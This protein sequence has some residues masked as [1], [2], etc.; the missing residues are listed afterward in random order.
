MP[1]Q[2][3]PY[4]A[5]L[6]RNGYD[7]TLL[8]YEKKRDLKEKGRDGIAAMRRDLAA[9]GIEWLYLAY[10]KNPP[11]LSTIFD[12]SV[13]CLRV[14]YIILSRR[15]KIVHLRG[16]TP[17]MMMLPLSRVTD[18]RTVFD[19]RGFLA[20]E[21]V[22]GGI[23]KEG[24]VSFRIVKKAE[25]RLLKTADAVTVLTRKHLDINRASEWLSGRRIPMDVVPCC[26]DT[27][28]FTIDDTSAAELRSRHG[29]NDNFVLMYPGKIGTFYFMK[30]MLDFYKALMAAEPGAV[31][32]IVTRDD[33]GPV[34]KAAEE[35][36]IGGDRVRIIKGPD[37][38][39]MPEY[40]RMADAGIFFIN[41]YKKMGSSP[42]KMGEFLASGVPVII[43]PGV[44]D[45]EE[46][47]RD[48]GVGVV[49]EHFK[50]DDYIK[51]A[52]EILALKGEGAAL[53]S[54]CRD[55]ALRHLSLE[56][57]V[58]KYSDIYEAVMSNR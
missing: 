53:R 30:E 48:N 39:R 52:R 21:Y 14:L 41:P 11:L 22:G 45:T 26:V 16:I 31:F 40:Y 20:E 28:R 37:Y 51:G 23:W 54:R 13:G 6:A 49:V 47:V 58:V 32:L 15:V 25:R 8:T 29:L 24:D 50:E 46:L 56:S 27:S 44:G 18:V 57:G 3:V 33:G 42:I 4:L 10:H 9:L 17:G 2:G 36:G 34:F 38:S 7:F 19:M 1:S 43:N 35:A 12:L 55:A 5:G